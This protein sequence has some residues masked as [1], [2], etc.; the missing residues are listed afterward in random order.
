MKAKNAVRS[1]PIGI[2]RSLADLLGKGYVEAVCSARAFTEGCDARELLA[3][4]NE[5]VDFYPESFARR[6]DELIPLV[7]T[8]VCEGLPGSAQGAG[9]R[10]FR[11]ASKTGPAPLTGLGFLR[12]G[13]DG[14][15]YL[16]SKAEHYHLSIGHSFPG[17]RLLETARRL[18]IPNTTHNNTRGHIART[19]EEELVAA[20]NG[21]T[22]SQRPE[23]EGVLASEGERVLNRVINLETGS[24]V[25]EAALKMVLARFYKFEKEHPEPRY[26]G[27]IPVILVMGDYEGGTAANY[28]GTTILTQVMRGLWPA[29]GGAL[30]KAGTFLVRP[31]R[32]ND[33]ADFERVLGQW[34]SGSHK[35]AAFFH[36]I[37]LMNYGAVRLEVE[38]LRKAY[39][40][41]RERDV[42]VVADEIQSCIWS[43]EIFM[44]REYGLSPDLVSAGKGFPGGEYPAARVLATP[45]M[46]SLQQFGALVTN[47]QEELASLAFLITIE[48]ARANADYT[49]ATGEYYEAELRALVKRRSDLLEKM[50]GKRHLA[51]LFFRDSQ[52]VTRF[53]QALNAAGIDISVQSYKA[54]CP[55][56]CL[57]KLPLTATPK[58]VDFLVGKMDEALKKLA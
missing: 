2:S 55:P 34:D 52:K 18:G 30:E 54:K 13:E 56:G 47:G 37:V 46:D 4:A 14:R 28:H 40:L 31:V 15:L 12:V 17:F 33:I 50:E 26:S 36:E 41:C 1:Y 5:K 49:R 58:A 48:F 6:V 25:V 10:G 32:I 8:K 57:T 29:V 53:V 22:R 16:A 23:L 44:F 39:A 24:L 9:T 43:P 27:R 19:L 11:E 45:A 3:A 35:V 38:Y 20:A 42:P 21:L 51:S 7:G